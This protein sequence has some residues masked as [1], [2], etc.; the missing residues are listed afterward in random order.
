MN[1]FLNLFPYILI[2]CIIAGKL[3]PPW[4]KALK[5]IKSKA[6]EQ[7]GNPLVRG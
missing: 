3:S 7:A 4:D 1:L 6:S 5:A 2:T